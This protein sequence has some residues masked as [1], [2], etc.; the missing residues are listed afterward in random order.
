MTQQD[1]REFVLTLSCPDR[2]GIVAAVSG[3][4]AERGCN[5]LE[6]QQFGDLDTATF[7]MRV[8]FSAPADVDADGL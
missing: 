8:Q 5:I 3:A 7:F 1:Q 4:L 2:P 6:S